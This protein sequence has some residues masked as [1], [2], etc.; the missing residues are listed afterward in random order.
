MSIALRI[1]AAARPLAW[2]DVVERDAPLRR[3]SRWRK[4]GWTGAAALVFLGLLIVVAV[5]GGPLWRW[6]PLNQ[7]MDALL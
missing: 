5:V 7:Y 6:N 1:P 3:P 2:E 4:L